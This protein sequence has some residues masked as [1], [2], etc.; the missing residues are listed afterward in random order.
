MSSGG[1][2]RPGDETDSDWLTRSR[3][4]SPGAAPWERA[5]ESE[6]P[7]VPDVP[8]DSDN[9]AAREAPLTVAD[10][11]AKINGD[12]PLPE[13]T[14]HRAQEEPEPYPDLD[15]LDTTILPVTVVPASEIP[16]LGGPRVPDR[17]R[18]KRTHRRTALM[19]R[20]AAALIAVL[21]LA[22]TGGAWQWQSA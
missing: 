5:I 15:D 6:V 16:H 8:D 14:R 19:G 3:R 4:S 22:L 13:P 17:V 18:R 10:L 11:I 20:A 2:D 1:D 7:D 9:V 12:A 21:A